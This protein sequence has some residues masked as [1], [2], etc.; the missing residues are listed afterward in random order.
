MKAYQIFQTIT[1]ELGREIFQNLRDDHRDVY[2]SVLASLAQQKKLRPV[3][4]QRK[5]ASQQ[6][7]WMLQTQSFVSRTA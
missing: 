2:K 3:F 7:D 1:P 6:I 5:P 4:V